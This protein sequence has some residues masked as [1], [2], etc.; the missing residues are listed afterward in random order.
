[1]GKEVVWKKFPLSWEV[2]RANGYGEGLS[3]KTLPRSRDLTSIAVSSHFWLP[4]KM[5]WTF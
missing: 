3:S 1:M 5:S 4:W 2:S